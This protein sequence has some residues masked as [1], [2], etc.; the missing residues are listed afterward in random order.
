M[1]MWQ[2]I[3]VGLYGMFWLGLVELPLRLL[4]PFAKFLD[5]T[6]RV[7]CPNCSYQ[8]PAIEKHCPEC[9]QTRRAEDA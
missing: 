2:I 9:R 4:A 6:P 8:M 1:P 7:I 5:K 3:A